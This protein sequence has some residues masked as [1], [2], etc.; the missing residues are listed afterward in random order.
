MKTA[1]AVSA[2]FVLAG[3]ASAQDEGYYT[4]PPTI[5]VTG[6]GTAEAEPDMATVV[7]GVDATGVTAAEAVDSASEMMEGA[8][9]AARRAGVSEDDLTT[10]YYSL[11]QEEIYD[12]DYGYTG[13][14]QYRV[15]ESVAAVVHDIDDVGAVIG[16]VVSGG[17]NTVSSITF[18][19]ENVMALRDEARAN[20]M[21]DAVGR[22]RLLAQEAGVTLGR[23]TSISEYSYDD[24]NYGYY[25][26]GYYSDYSYSMTT[27]AGEAMS[28]PTIY[29]AVTKYSTSV[30]VTYYLEEEE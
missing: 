24:S 15:T 12:Y 10:T 8:R 19:V 5:S 2:L 23:I 25:G 3:F 21:E 27:A 28:A 16:A 26:G 4:Y 7:F 14:Y 1:L 22:A 30:S 6:Y 13:E 9:A 20:A 29:P 17:A 18:S 11:Y